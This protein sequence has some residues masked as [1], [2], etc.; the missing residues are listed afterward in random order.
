MSLFTIP[1]DR[2]PATGLWGNAGATEDPDGP[3]INVVTDRGADPTGVTNAQ[4]IIQQAIYD[5]SDAGNNTVVYIPAGTYLMNSGL[6]SKNNGGNF[7]LGNWKLRGEVDADGVWLTHLDFH[8]T[9]TNRALVLGT[10]PSWASPQTITAGLTKGSTTVTVA[11]TSAF[12]LYRHNRIYLTMDPAENWS[13]S[14]YPG[15][16]SNV[17]WDVLVTGKTSTTITF[18][19][20]VPDDYTTIQKTGATIE[21]WGGGALFSVVIQDIHFD[22]TNSG[23]YA[24]VAIKAGLA[25]NCIFRNIKTTNHY[26]YSLYIYDSTN[27][28]IT[29]SWFGPNLS[30]GSNHAGLLANTTNQVLITHNVIEQNFPRIEVNFGTVGLVFASNFSPYGVISEITTNHGPMNQMN[31]YESNIATFAASD[32]TFGGETSVMH[33]RNWYT[34]Q[35]EYLAARTDTLPFTAK[36]FTRRH[37]LAANLLQSPGFA[38]DWTTP[39]SLGY[40]NRNNGFSTGGTVNSTTGTWWIDTTAGVGKTWNGILTTRT[41]DVSGIVTLDTGTGTSMATHLANTMYGENAV[42]WNGNLAY[43]N[44][45]VGD[46]AT[47]SGVSSPAPLPAQGSSILF[48]VS[49]RGYQELDAG[50]Y[51]IADGGTFYKLGNWNYIDNGVPSDEAVGSTTF[52]AS[53]YLASADARWTASGL[54]WPPFGPDVTQPSDTTLDQ[55]PA[56]A[57][58]ILNGAWPSSGGSII[59]VN[60]SL[61]PTTITF[62]S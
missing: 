1:S 19:N 53:L 37:S 3:I 26:N 31:L 40:P 22:C 38:G 48:T 24:D 11:D 30:G 4:P 59:T 8:L 44:T 52:P 49:I 13:T 20:P 62:P 50:T 17:F 47:L 58:F 14:Y 18:V 25:H 55:I 2:S 57:R 45:L 23:D 32:G 15:Q 10:D 6:A 51:A 35:F 42:N 28:L 9:S 34:G 54:A 60:G 46:V 29:E 56:S 27:C 43:I 21:T 39:Y 7:P 5:A 33:Y 41:D 16:T 36:R 61:A 12:G